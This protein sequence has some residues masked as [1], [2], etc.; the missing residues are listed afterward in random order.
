M[1]EGEEKERNKKRRK[2]KKN[3]FCGEGGFSRAGPALLAVQ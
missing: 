1:E 3:N 2:E